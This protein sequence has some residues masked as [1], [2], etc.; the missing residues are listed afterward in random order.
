MGAKLLVSVMGGIK[1]Y[2]GLGVGEDQVS[3]I[4]FEVTVFTGMAKSRE[5]GGGLVVASS[6]E[7]TT[8]VGMLY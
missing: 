7:S 3:I 2:Y 5:W 6:E 1:C 4:V 8:G